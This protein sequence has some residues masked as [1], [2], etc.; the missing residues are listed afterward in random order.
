MQIVL[1]F[2]LNSFLQWIVE[3]D[4]Q[5]F[6][7][8]NQKLTNPFFDVV[9]PF[10]R[11]ST[12]WIPLYIALLIFV[13]VKFKRKVIIWIVFAVITILLTDQLSSHIIK[14][15]VAR[16]R[17]CNDLIFSSQ[18]R[19]LLKNC[20]PGFSF[21][22]S[23]ACNH[24]GIAVYIFLTLSSFVKNWKYLFLFWAAAISYAQVYVGVHY[25]IDIFFGGLLGSFIAYFTAKF[26]NKKLIP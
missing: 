13:I 16:A 22:S 20:S 14:P 8:I 15:L 12:N 4:Q 9:M 2:G 17:P 10:L 24:F 7:I 11:H 3:L 23:H 19:L 21:T 25:P 18:V 5:F 6:L 1:I 26:A